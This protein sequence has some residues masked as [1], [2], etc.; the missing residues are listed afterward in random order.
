L[1]KRAR[2]MLPPAKNVT[3]SNTST[4]FHFSYSIPSTYTVG[5]L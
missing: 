5:N 4:P 2:S 3:K 1:N